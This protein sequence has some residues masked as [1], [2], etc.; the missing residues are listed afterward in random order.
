MTAKWDPIKWLN[1]AANRSLG[2]DASAA[3]AFFGSRTRNIQ[4]TFFVVCNVQSLDRSPVCDHLSC[5]S[6]AKDTCVYAWLIGTSR[7][8]VSSKNHTDDT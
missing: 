7:H 3:K 6:V 2:L 4:F 5:T 1:V 8:S